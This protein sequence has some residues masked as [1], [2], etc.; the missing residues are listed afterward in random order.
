MLTYLDLHRQASV[1]LYLQGNTRE[2]VV[3]IASAAE[4]ILNIVLCHMQWGRRN[5][6]QASVR[7]AT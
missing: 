6:P 7:F 5:D 4:A 1:A 2:S 3:M